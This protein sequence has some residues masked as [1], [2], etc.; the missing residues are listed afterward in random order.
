[1]SLPRK[2]VNT[3]LNLLTKNLTLTSFPNGASVTSKRGDA[4]FEWNN[5]MIAL[6][7]TDTDR[8]LAEQ[9]GCSLAR[10]HN[11]RI[12]LGIPA[13]GWGNVHMGIWKNWWARA[14]LGTK[15]DR[16]IAEELGVSAQTVHKQRKRLG[17][18]PYKGPRRGKMFRG[19][20]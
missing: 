6:L 19:E 5:K 1:M 3:N 16:K 8:A 15:V 20:R 17:I 10:V 7:G 11:K 13:F 12:A 2:L 18:P 4:M 14:I 9:F